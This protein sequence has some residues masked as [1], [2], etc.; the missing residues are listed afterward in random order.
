MRDSTIKIVRAAPRPV[1]PPCKGGEGAKPHYTSPCVGRSKHEAFRGGAGRGDRV[2]WLYFQRHKKIPQP[3]TPKTPFLHPRMYCRDTAAPHS[4][5]TAAQARAA[6][7]ASPEG[8]GIEIPEQLC[9]RTRAGRPPWQSQRLKHGRRSRRSGPLDPHSEGRGNGADDHVWP[10]PAALNALL[11]FQPPP[12][13]RWRPEFAVTRK[14]LYL[15]DTTLRGGA[16]WGGLLGG[17]Q[18]P[19]RAGADSPHRHIEGGWPGANPTDTASSPSV[20]R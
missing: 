1:S 17:G 13:A 12:R 18:A 14:R 15:F 8:E 19:N 10:P 4:R 16:G 3:L 2:V 5:L 6:P 7:P 9:C 11:A 20:R